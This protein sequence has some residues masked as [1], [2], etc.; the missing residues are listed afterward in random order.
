M[1]IL[2]VNSGRN[3]TAYQQI[4]NSHNEIESVHIAENNITAPS[5]VIN[6][7]G[8]NIKISKALDTEFIGNLLEICKEKRIDYLFSFIDYGLPELAENRHEFEALGTY[9]VISSYET[10]IKCEDKFAFSRYLKKNH[11]SAV[12][13]FL[14]NK[15]QDIYPLPYFAKPRYGNTSIGAKVINKKDEI[16]YYLM[17]ED[18][19]I[20]PYLN[21]KIYGVD[22]L[23]KNGQIYDVFM[24]E[25]LTSRA[26]TTDTSKSLWDD[27]ILKLIE[28]LA[29]IFDF[30]GF[31]DID[32]LTKEDECFI[33]E[34]NPR[35]GGA[36][37]H[38]IACGKNFFKRYLNNLKNKNFVDYK[39]N[40]KTI[41]YEKT[42]IAN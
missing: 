29:K 42:I 9:V 41:K 1:N 36:Y 40:L 14:D 35:F 7:T 23:V 19:I 4:I 6:T 28:S 13:T 34:I 11:I 37:T 10:V 33:S 24:R 3:V 25:T 30:D 15:I 26:G 32:I 17:K 18:Y 12:P 22:L 27:K 2:L 39:L 21:G 16:E 38:A 31:I 8:D 5:C 20:Q